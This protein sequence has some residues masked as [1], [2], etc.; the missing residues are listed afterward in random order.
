MYRDTRSPSSQETVAGG[1]LFER[2]CNGEP[3]LS[4]SPE[5]FYGLA[6]DRLLAARCRFLVG[7]AYALR[8]YTGICRET[9]DLDLFCTQSETTAILRELADLGF[10]T[11]ITNPHWLA[12]AFCDDRYIDLIFSSGNGICTVDDSWYDFAPSGHVLG[13]DV[14]LVPPEEMVWSKVFIQERQ[15]FDG[16]DVLHLI[17]CMHETLDWNR[18]LERLDPHWEVLLA[19]L[20]NYRFVYPADHGAI[21]SWVMENLLT[22][23]Q[24]QTR[25]ANPTH[26]V[27]RGNLLSSEQ[28]H[29]DFSRWGYRS[30]PRRGGRAEVG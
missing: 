6:I 15:R 13:R 23:A 24:E 20:L 16:A 22:R 18:L 25:V 27:C 4:C 29:V 1:R 19:H 10:R 8:V 2:F 11:E 14:R 7:G 26:L 9:K 28:Y 17:R 5:R 21:P 12:K 30:L 3:H